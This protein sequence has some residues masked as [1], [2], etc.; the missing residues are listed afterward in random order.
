MINRMAVAAIV[1]GLTA[2]SAVSAQTTQPTSAQ[3]AGAAVHRPLLVCDTSAATRQAFA[4]EHG[5]A[6][7]MTAEQIT[8]A[9][10]AGERWA[11][12]RC[13]SDAE[14]AR[15]RQMRAARRVA[16]ASR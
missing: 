13:V 4:S 12:P 3:A 6:V 1:M 9:A 2:A 16:V 10:A 7:Y 5:A 15:Y 11:T 8:A 14:L